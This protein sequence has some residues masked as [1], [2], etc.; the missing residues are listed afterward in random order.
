MTRT[1]RTI[2]ALTIALSLSTTAACSVSNVD[3]RTNPLTVLRSLD[4]A[5]T[6]K[7]MSIRKAAPIDDYTVWVNHDA[8]LSHAEVTKGDHTH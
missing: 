3:G 6:V 2:I 5:E 4:N 8:R 1:I 7:P